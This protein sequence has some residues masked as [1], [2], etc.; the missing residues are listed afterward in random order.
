MKASDLIAEALIAHGVTHVYEMVGGMITHLLDSIDRRG[1]TH[2]ISVHHE[3]AAAFAVDGHARMS[4]IPAVAMATSG[5][6][7]TNLLTGIGSC[8]FDSTPSVFITGQVNRHE[9]KGDRGIRQLGF[10][11]TDIVSMARA[12]TKAAW[13]VQDPSKLQ[14]SLDEAFHIARSGRPGPVL[15]DI[16]MDVQRVELEP[17][18]A[19][20]TKDDALIPN[21][22]E[23]R[24][25][26]ELIRS[27]H[28]PLMLLGGGIRSAHA[29]QSLRLLLQHARIP[30]VHSLM[31]VD[32]LDHEHPLRVGMIGNYGNRYANQTL[33]TSDVLIVIGSRLD[34][35]QTGADV[36]S[37]SNGR[38]IIHVDCEQGE[39]NNRIR[40]C[41]A[42]CS[43]AKAFLDAS[44][45]EVQDGF[46]AP[47]EWIEKIKELKN[48]SPDSSEIRNCSGINPNCLMHAISE[49][50]VNASAFVADVGQHQ[51]WAAQSLRLHAEQRF[52]TSGGMGSM[53]FA[54][55]AAIGAAFASAPHPIVVI[56][57]DGGFQCNIHEL[58]TVVRNK[59]PLKMV[60]IDN[61]CHGMVRQFQETYFDKRYRSTL[62]GY[63]APNFAEVARAY[64]IASKKISAPGEVTGA[65]SWLWHNPQEP[66]LLHVHIESHLNAY[67]KMAFGK[68][69][70]EM[71]PDSK[72]IGMEST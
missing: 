59:L 56:A 23:V 53:G 11:E 72:P 32:L 13:T 64:G 51:M 10:Q 4:G 65:M 5:P 42:I 20:N 18:S 9:M 49:S 57:G 25:A 67:P 2:I 63:S 8:Y 69:I 3:Q 37:F 43:D 41:I 54:L 58:Q 22:A 36:S 48:A 39:V 46:D 40:G 71:E 14:G 15:I 33:G 7:A 27:A 28:R 21:S 60:V 17:R 38:Q 6:G 68:P 50:S 34:I 55:P 62:Q 35:R 31:G 29:T 52:L 70:T 26:W 30:V 61:G 44:L 1:V 16:P 12:V 24:S 47:S 19:R 66:L 45:P